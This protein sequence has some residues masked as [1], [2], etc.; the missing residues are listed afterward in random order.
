MSAAG[1]LGPNLVTTTTAYERNRNMSEREYLE[2]KCRRRRVWVRARVG[3]YSFYR[4]IRYP[5]KF[6][7][8]VST[9]FTGNHV[10]TQNF[11]KM[12]TKLV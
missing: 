1:L 4:I 7:L 6:L 2:A 5:V 3:L 8:A 10:L 11:Q 9:F 12:V